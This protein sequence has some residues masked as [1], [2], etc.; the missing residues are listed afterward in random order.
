MGWPTKLIIG[1]SRVHPLAY[2]ATYL[3]AVPAFGLAYAFFCA[4]QF[5]A[6]YARYEPGAV[7]DR[8]ALASDFRDAIRQSLNRQ[9]HVSVRSQGIDWALDPES[10]RVSNIASVD[11]SQVT[12]TVLVNAA[13]E[14]RFAGAETYNW[15]VN[16]RVP[17]H[18]IT[19]NLSPPVLTYRRPELED[20]SS[21]SQPL[22][23]A[24]FNQPSDSMV[25]GPSLALN[26]EQD[27]Q[28]ERYL[29]GIRGDASAF[30][31]QVGRMMYLSAV[32]ITT[33]GLGDILPMTARARLLVAAEAISG[34]VLAGLFLNA[35]AYRAS[36]G[37]SSQRR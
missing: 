15:P 5:Y 2:V 18:P 6:P 30:S 29:L 4:H 3:A 12:F 1:L 27:A 25:H 11:G 16:V 34:I 17:L 23:Q 10:V 31:G 35:I 28:L 8:L 32:V 22:F 36:E 20:V 7:A 19:R 14:E 33:L 13:G 24:V 9:G 37:R 26:L 21:F